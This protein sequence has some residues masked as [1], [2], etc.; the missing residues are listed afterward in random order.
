MA[1]PA[2]VGRV[3]K[4]M[5]Q[6]SHGVRQTRRDLYVITADPKQEYLFFRASRPARRMAEVFARARDLALTHNDRG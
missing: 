6:A 1:N 3:K 4:I 5:C 2:R